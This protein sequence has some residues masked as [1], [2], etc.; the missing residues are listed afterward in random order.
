[1]PT[2]KFERGRMRAAVL[3][4]AACAAACAAAAA[5]AGGAVEVG[6]A[7]MR[8]RGGGALGADAAARARRRDDTRDRALRRREAPFAALR[9]SRAAHIAPRA[10]A[11][12]RAH[13]LARVARPRAAAALRRDAR[14]RQD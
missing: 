9:A 1:M 8:T 10:I 13:V 14:A 3:F 6:E 11:F 4:V 2:G 5:A 12:A 7:P